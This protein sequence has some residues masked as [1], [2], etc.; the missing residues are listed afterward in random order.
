MKRNSKIICLVFFFILIA[1]SSHGARM[2]VRISSLNQQQYTKADIEAEV[3]FGRNLAARILANYSLWNNPN[4]NRYVNLV[5]KVLSMQTGRSEL[6]FTFG[7]LDTDSV[8]AFATPGGYIFITRGALQQMRNEAELAA[9]LGHEMAHVLNRHMVKELNLHAKSG[10]ALSGLVELIGGATASVR[11]SLEASLDQAVNILYKR[12]YQLKDELEADRIG[13]MIAAAAE[14]D[15]SRL[16]AYLRR[17]GQF[18]VPA[19]T[20]KD[21]PVLKERLAAISKTIANNGLNG[22]SANTNEERLH[23]MVSF[24]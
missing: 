15:A 1:G 19:Q 5:G 14:Y 23:E 2:R 22:V 21:H 18:E 24:D 3:V 7:I 12:G 11:S 20:K 13:L 8:N 17:V 10:S 4:A 9:V 6:I 16:G